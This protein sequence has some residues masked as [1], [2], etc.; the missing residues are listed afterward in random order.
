MTTPVSVVI[1]QAGSAGKTT[2]AVTLAALEGQAG[3]VVLLVDLD[4]QGNASKWLGAD[5]AAVTSTSGDVLL[6][7]APVERAVITDTTA[8]GVYLLPAT[9]ALLRDEV[10]LG[11]SY[12]GEQRLRNLIADLPASLG[13]TRVVIDCAGA[14]NTMGVSA[15]IAATS[16]VTVTMPSGKELE[17]IPELERTIREIAAA[18]RLDLRLDAI[19]PCAVPPASKGQAYQDALRLLNEVYGALVTSPVRHSVRVMEAYDR[20]LPVTAH[21]PTH[22]VSLDYRQVH[23]DL[24]RLGVLA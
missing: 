7:K 8:P 10:E 1:N 14:M 24:K 2:S 17:G 15:L 23:T 5:L 4:S 20:R 13:I 19:I 22:P 16:V 21:A 9:G 3:A 6:G 18:Y 12:G 11:R